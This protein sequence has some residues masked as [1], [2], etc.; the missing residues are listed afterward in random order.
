MSQG[1]AGGSAQ[2]KFRALTRAWRKRKRKVFAVVTVVC[3]SIFIFSWI[4]A[5]VWPF[6]T[7]MFGLWAGASMCFWMTARTSPPAWIEQ[8]QQGAFGEQATGKQLK[9]LE[10]EGWVVL[11]DLPRGDGN[12]DHV[13]IGP[14]GV[15]VLDTKRIDGRVIVEDGIVTVRR[16]DDPELR[17]E[18][19]G[20]GHLLR[21]AS[22]THHRVLAASR[23]NVWVT[24]VM[25]WWADFPQRVISGRCTHVQGEDLV[26]WLRDRPAQLA[27]SRLEQV[28]N[29]VRTAWPSLAAE[30]SAPDAW[31][32]AVEWSYTLMA[33]RP[34]AGRSS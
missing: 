23:I 19:R 31:A 15:F 5:H 21:L 26:Q 16:I 30:R 34:V 7:F 28:A 10:R 29:A 24:P 8:W 13:L 11:H 25:V 2:A 1:E 17:Y 18:H 3:G 9:E 6:W 12:V 20:T 27:P 22:E 33:G 32:I 4:A 14:G